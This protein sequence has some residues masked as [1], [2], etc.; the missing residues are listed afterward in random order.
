MTML[1][2]KKICLI[3]AALTDRAKVYDW[4]FHSETTKFHS[5]P[6]DYPEKEIPTYEEFCTAYYEDYF[7]TGTRPSDGQGF[8][9]LNADEAI[10]YISYSTFHLKPALAE[11]DIWMNCE[12]N[13]GKG[14]GV[15]ALNVLSDYLNQT[16]GSKQ[17]I[18]APS[19][20]NTWALKAYGKAGFKKTEKKMSAFLREE[21]AA[22]YENGDYGVE[23]TAILTKSFL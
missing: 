11:L 9:I 1:Q 18:I 2:G 21:Y 14:F 6:P 7:F 12:V 4:C 17:I 19:I 3:P 23:E 13:C 20:K 16:I 22:L 5:G 10:G 15:D 8:L